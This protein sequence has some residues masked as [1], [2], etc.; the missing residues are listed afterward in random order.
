M[1]VGT[2]FSGG[3]I[4]ALV[5]AMCSIDWLQTEFPGLLD[6]NEAGKDLVISTV[7]GGSLAQALWTNIPAGKL[8]FPKYDPDLSYESVNNETTAN[9][10][11]WWFAKGLNVLPPIGRRRL[12]ERLSGGGNKY[13]GFLDE[14]VKGWVGSTWEDLIYELYKHEYG[15]DELKGGDLTWYNDFSF[16]PIDKAPLKLNDYR[17]MDDPL[18]SAGMGYRE[19]KTGQMYPASVNATI[20]DAV[21]WSSAFWATQPLESNIVEFE[22]LHLGLPRND[23]FYFADGGLIGPAAITNLLRAQTDT[24]V[25]FYNNLGDIAKRTFAIAMLFGIN[26]KIKSPS[27]AGG[28]HTQVFPKELGAEVMANLTNPKILRARLTNVPVLDNEWLGIKAYT[29]KTLIIVSTM[30]NDE[31]VDSFKDTRI[32]ENLGSGLLGGFPTNYLS[33]MPTLDA[34]M[35]CMLQEWRS[36]KYREEIAAALNQAA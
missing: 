23:D 27:M 26:S 14:G 36:N 24:V 3:G 25:A 11:Q 16:V 17:Y 33:G 15:I 32:K 28:I 2:A 19:M 31:F 9:S 4:V 22:L 7:S 29:L 30:Y 6:P 5:G 13:G 35:L 12:P 1:T 21:S 18:G 20:L 10:N 34:N 8:Y